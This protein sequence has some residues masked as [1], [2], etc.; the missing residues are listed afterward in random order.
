MVVSRDL[1]PLPTSSTE[2]IVRPPGLAGPCRTT[3]RRALRRLAGEQRF[4]DLV[5]S[6]NEMHGGG[7]APP[8]LVSPSTAQLACLGRLREDVENMGPPDDTTDAGAFREL[9]GSRPG[10]DE[11]GPRVSYQRE[12][13]SFPPA[14]LEAA[15]PAD[16]LDGRELQYWNNWRETLR[17]PAEQAV[18]LRAQLGLVRPYSDPLLVRDRAGYAEFIRTLVDAGIV[19][20]GPQIEATVGIFFVAKSNGKQ[21][22][23]FDTRIINTSYRD[24]EHTSLP[25]ASAWANIQIPASSCLHMAQLD[26]D[27]AFYRMRLPK[28]AEDDFILPALRIADL[29]KA[30]ARLA[31]ELEGQTWLSS[32]L[33]VL[34]MGSVGRFIFVK[35]LS[36]ARFWK[37]A[38]IWICLFG[39]DTT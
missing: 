1:F 37:L 20:L 5:D 9:C 35:L 27:N 33:R 22:I 31:P 10:Y 39:I 38:L 13:I 7:S 36:F 34:P 4:N 14:G 32:Y 15:E 11:P 2:Q 8:G 26:I 18:M 12:L 23:I 28:A 21:R 19:G 29:H 3:R 25:S 16:L 17:R 30:G 24:P 6:L